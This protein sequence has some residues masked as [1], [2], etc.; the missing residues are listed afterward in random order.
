VAVHELTSFHFLYCLAVFF[1]LL[2]LLST[3]I[4]V[5]TILCLNYYIKVN[6]ILYEWLLLLNPFCFCETEYLYFTTRVFGHSAISPF[7]GGLILCHC[8][9]MNLIEFVKF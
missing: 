9:F 6:K 8:N 1:Q 2:R 3:D 5:H 7:L 4:L